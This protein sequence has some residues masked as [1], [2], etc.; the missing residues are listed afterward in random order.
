MIRSP[1]N[2]GGARRRAG[3]AETGSDAAAP[4]AMRLP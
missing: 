2:R 1:C 4:P 3:A